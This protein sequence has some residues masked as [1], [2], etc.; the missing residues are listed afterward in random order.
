ML[1]EQGTLSEAFGIEAGYGDVQREA[2][3]G[4]GVWIHVPPREAKIVCLLR[5]QPIRYFA[6]WQGGR[7][8]PCPGRGQCGLCAANVGGKTRYVYSVFDTRLG[9]AGLVEVSPNTAADIRKGCEEM[10]FAKGVTFSLTKER[11]VTNGRIVA[12]CL[13]KMFA[14][15]DLPEGPDPVAVL[16]RMW[17][18][19]DRE[20]VDG[21]GF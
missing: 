11:Q 21:S 7:I 15:K 18:L 13:H 5:E 4:P 17:T 10:G 14:S 19:P 9:L 3:E 12:K 6:H 20:R 2:L 8:K 16:T 1:P